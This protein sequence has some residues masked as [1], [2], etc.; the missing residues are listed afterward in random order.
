MPGATAVGITF[1]VG[2]V[3]VSEKRIA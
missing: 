2:V 3:F 1:D